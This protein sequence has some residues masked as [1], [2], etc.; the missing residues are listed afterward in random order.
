MEQHAHQE[1]NLIKNDFYL[2]DEKVQKAAETFIHWIEPQKWKP[3]QKFLEA[4]LTPT[5]DFHFIQNVGFFLVFN[6]ETSKD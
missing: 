1:L 4:S 3:I 6:E 5:K 2:D